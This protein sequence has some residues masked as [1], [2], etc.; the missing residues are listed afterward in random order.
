M[1]NMYEILA[2]LNEVTNRVNINE[3]MS[4]HAKGIEKFGRDGMKEL[5][6]LGREGASEKRMDAARKKYNKYDEDVAQEGNR[7]AYNVLKA[8]EKGLK[9][10][11]LDGD[12]DLET[13][14]EANKPMSSKQ[15]KFAAL[16]DPKDKI[17]YADKIAG[18]KMKNKKRF[19]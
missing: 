17:T 13:V 6:D 5:A 18:A 8:K 1:N 14:R 2:K 3:G 9:K 7:F 10:A 16:A 12:G 15:K 4:R 11:D 19:V